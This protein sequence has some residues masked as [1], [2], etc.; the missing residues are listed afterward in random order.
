MGTIFIFFCGDIRQVEFA[1]NMVDNN[2]AIL[3]SF[4]NGIFTDLNMTEPFAR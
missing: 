2:T 4:T 1:C 3:N